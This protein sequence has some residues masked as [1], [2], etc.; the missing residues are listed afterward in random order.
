MKDSKARPSWVLKQRVR[1]AR[2]TAIAPCVLFAATQVYAAEPAPNTT[3]ATPPNVAWRVLDGTAVLVVPSSPSVQTLN[4]V[5]T[6][7]WALSD[8]RSVAAIVDAIV[9]EFEVERTQAALDVERFVREL[10]GKQ[11]LIV[12]TR[13]AEESGR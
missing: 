2:S 6:A 12:E 3:P 11:M 9:N 8:G 4:P 10:E 7:V 13:G 5:G 1:I